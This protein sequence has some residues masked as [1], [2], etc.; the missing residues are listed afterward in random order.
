MNVDTTIVLEQI[1]NI[2]RIIT[3][4]ILILM[5]WYA[6]SIRSLIA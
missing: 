3:T 4:V 1:D 5:Q 6:K 2:D